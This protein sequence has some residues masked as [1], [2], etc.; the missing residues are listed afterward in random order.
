MHTC[1]LNYSIL[2][3]NSGDE[4]IQLRKYAREQLA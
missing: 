4:A 2:P 1:H 3:A